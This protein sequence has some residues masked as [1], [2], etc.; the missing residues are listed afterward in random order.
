[1]VAK[2]QL[3]ASTLSQVRL[4]ARAIV[5]PEGLGIASEL[6]VWQLFAEQ[7]RSLKVR[8]VVDLST[9]IAHFVVDEADPSQPWTLSMEIP[10]SMPIDMFARNYVDKAG[11]WYLAS[12]TNTY[13][14]FDPDSVQCLSSAF[15]AACPDAYV[16][17]FDPKGN[18]RYLV[19]LMG[20][21][22]DDAMGITTDPGGNVF[23]LR[24]VGSEVRGC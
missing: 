6:G 11:N 21:R 7:K 13:A 16:V 2:F 14:N 23:V 8:V 19:Y 9:G 1:M 10:V 3:S 22:Y 18:L 17:S 24:E 20:S 4:Q 15:T 12:S 5:A